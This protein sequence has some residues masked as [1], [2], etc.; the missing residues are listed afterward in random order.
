MTVTAGRDTKHAA[1]CFVLL[2]KVILPTIGA[3]GWHRL[4]HHDIAWFGINA[5]HHVITCCIPVETFNAG[6]ILNQGLRKLNRIARETTNTDEQ[7]SRGDRVINCQ[8]SGS[9]ST[10][11]WCKPGEITFFLQTIV[12]PGGMD[13]SV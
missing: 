6:K 7:N 8:K 9:V 5:R 1:V 11:V 2:H 12:K 4:L 10:A 3:A 13:E